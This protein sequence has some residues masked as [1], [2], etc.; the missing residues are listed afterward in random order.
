MKIR[1]GWLAPAVIAALVV[2]LST[3][4]VAAN[5][6]SNTVHIGNCTTEGQFVSCSVQGD[7]VNPASIKVRVTTSGAQ[8]GKIDVS[9]FD[10]CSTET[11]SGDRNGDFKLSSGQSRSI[12]L[13]AGHRGTCTPDVDASITGAGRF[14][15]RLTATP[16]G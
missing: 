1:P 9:W 7:V 4:A 16:A 6:G 10:S 11:T 15:V 3:T 12:P 2:G 13:A 8:A 5:A 14:T